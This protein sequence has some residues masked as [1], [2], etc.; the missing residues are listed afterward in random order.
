MAVVTLL[1]GLAFFCLLAMGFW[2]VGMRRRKQHSGHG[3]STSDYVRSDGDGYV[4]FGLDHLDP[5]R[6]AHTGG[7]VSGVKILSA[8][9]CCWA[10]VLRRRKPL[11]GFGSPLRRVREVRSTALHF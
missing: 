3:C 1:R 4:Y 5:Q 7:T 2:H 8:K 11:L 10:R 9:L 6:K